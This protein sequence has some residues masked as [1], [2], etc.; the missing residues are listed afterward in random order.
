MCVSRFSS[1]NPL[2]SVS[3][4]DRSESSYPPPPYHPSMADMNNNHPNYAGTGG[5]GYMPM[6]PSN[7]SQQNSINFFAMYGYNG[8]IS[9]AKGANPHEVYGTIE[10]MRLIQS[11]KHDYDPNKFSSSSQ[12]QIGHVEDDEINY[13]DVPPPPPPPP[14]PSC[15]FCKKQG[16]S[17]AVRMI[18]ELKVEVCRDC[19]RE[20]WRADFD[21]FWANNNPDV[22]K[23]RGK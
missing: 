11:G 21:E 13:A 19:L 15:N 1:S 9:L 2:I 22:K 20:H 6:N 23:R 7:N 8:N 5:G 18:S 4:V 3:D 12:R 16:G 14:E 10:K 17:D